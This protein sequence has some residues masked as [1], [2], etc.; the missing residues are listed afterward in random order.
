MRLPAWL[1]ASVVLVGACGVF[2]GSQ[3]NSWS[4][5][6]VP[7]GAC[8]EQARQAAVGLSGITDLEIE[9]A[10]VPCT[11]AGG[12]GVA[13]ITLASGQTVTR[14]WSYVGDPGP[15][16]AAV[17]IGLPASTCQ[18]QADG[19]VDTISPSKHVVS[20]TVTCTKAPCTDANGEA[21]I[22][23]LLGDGT[24]DSTSSSWNNQ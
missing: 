9:C 16:P 19:Q 13:H 20:V 14:A 24:S 5:G 17:C 22:K 10:A 11:R 3:V 21:D 23:V 6:D 18:T 15:V 2:G 8:E 7:Q 1:I 12:R 4:C